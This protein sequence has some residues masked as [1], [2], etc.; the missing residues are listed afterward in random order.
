MGNR[1]VFMGRNG[2][3]NK[4]PS[5]AV[6]F[7]EEFRIFGYT[8]EALNRIGMA[9]YFVGVVSNERAKDM[10]GRRQQPMVQEYQRAIQGIT[11]APIDFMYC[12]DTHQLKGNSR[13][14]RPDMITALA[15][16]HGLDI[17]QSVMVVG[18]EAERA[19]AVAAGIPTIISVATGKGDM[20]DK[21]SLAHRTDTLLEAALY[22]ERL[23]GNHG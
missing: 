19:A 18:N 16:Q 11:S 20:K 9:G 1:A 7:R 5:R 21:D 17:E 23:N 12:Y 4:Q 3:I 8:P 6:M 14:P 15:E 10:D 2:I 22:I 13:L